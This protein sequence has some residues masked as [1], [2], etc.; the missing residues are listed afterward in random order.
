MA[1]RIRIT[2]KQLCQS[3]EAG[4]ISPLNSASRGRGKKKPVIDRNTFACIIN[5]S[6]SNLLSAQFLK[7]AIIRMGFRDFH[8]IL[9]DAFEDSKGCLPSGLKIANDLLNRN[10]YSI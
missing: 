7:E 10:L 3:L 8:D 4:V 2:Y 1:I 9:S 5:Q 6:L